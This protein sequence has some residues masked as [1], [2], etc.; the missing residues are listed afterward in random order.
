MPR[1]AMSGSF[2]SLYGIF[3]IFTEQFRSPDSHIGFDLFDIIT[4]GQL[5]STPMI[6]IGLTLIILAFR[7]NKNATIS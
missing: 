4:R 3:R 6:L 2:L 5:L 7:E 1:M